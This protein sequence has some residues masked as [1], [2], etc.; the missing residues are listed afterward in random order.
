MRP[1]EPRGSCP[2]D[3]GSHGSS[4]SAK[5]FN[6]VEHEIV[7]VCVF[8]VHAEIRSKR[9]SEHSHSGTTTP[10]AMSRN[11]FSPIGNADRCK[12]F[13]KRC[14]FGRLARIYHYRGLG[15]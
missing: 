14:T 11:A 3:G 5:H 1:L 9:F 13:S 10:P 12:Q 15:L 8:L 7:T 4:T 6:F 2:L